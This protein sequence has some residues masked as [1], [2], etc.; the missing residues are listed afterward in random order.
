[1]LCMNV[2]KLYINHHLSA[3]EYSLLLRIQKPSNYPISANQMPS[4]KQ[5]PTPCQIIMTPGVLILSKKLVHLLGAIPLHSS[6]LNA[7]SQANTKTVHEIFWISLPYV[8]GKVLLAMPELSGPFA[9]GT[10][11]PPGFLGSNSGSHVHPTKPSKVY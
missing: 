2:R 7:T 3:F 4:S 9:F 8:T 11:S 5:W 10:A 1:M 6:Q